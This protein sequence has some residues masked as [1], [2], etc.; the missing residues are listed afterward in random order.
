MTRKRSATTRFTVQVYDD[1]GQLVLST[2]AVTDGKETHFLH[3]DFADVTQTR[4]N[5]LA[6]ALGA[7]GFMAWRK[8]LELRTLFDFISMSAGTAEDT[9]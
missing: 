6:T 9:E 4:M 1:D 7:A 3:T 5:K 8:K 2:V